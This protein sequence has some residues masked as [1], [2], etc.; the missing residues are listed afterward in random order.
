V[1]LLEVEGL[2][3]FGRGPR[4]G[5][6]QLA[7]VTLVYGENSSGKSTLVRALAMVAQLQRV[8]GSVDDRHVHWVD[9]GPWFS[10]GQPWDALGDGADWLQWRLTL[11]VNGSDW[12]RWR[13]RLRWEDRVDW[14]VRWRGR[15]EL[16]ATSS[17]CGW[18]G[19]SGRTAL[20]FEGAGPGDGPMVGQRLQTTSMFED[21]ERAELQELLALQEQEDDLMRLAGLGERE[22]SGPEAQPGAAR[23]ALKRLWSE[24]DRFCPQLIEDEA[25]SD[26]LDELARRLQPRLGQDR[27]QLLQRAAS[28]VALARATHEDTGGGLRW[29]DSEAVPW[30]A[31][32]AGVD[33][34][35]DPL[36]RTRVGSTRRR[37]G[38]TRRVVQ[39]RRERAS[40]ALAAR[41][42]RRAEALRGLRELLLSTDGLIGNFLSALEYVPAHRLTPARSYPALPE[43]G[44][45]AGAAVVRALFRDAALRERVSASADGLFGVQLT[46]T[47]LLSQ[48]GGETRPS[49]ML[50]L[51]VVEEDGASRSIAD[52]G[53][54]V[55]QVLPMLAAAS[56]PGCAVIEEP[57]SNLHPTA[58]AG[59]VRALTAAAGVA[60]DG[61]EHGHPRL[62]L[63]TH[64]EHILRQVLQLV[65]EGQ[66]RDDQVAINYVSRVGP[67]S[68]C[69]RVRTRRGQLLDPLLPHD[70]DSL[71]HNPTLSQI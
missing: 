59:L 4:R 62:V 11:S 18:T 68:S 10:L 41:E 3:G 7:P 31:G 65:E 29:P 33:F 15:D 22:L 70:R 69:R 49:G 38:S 43:S 35:W 55:A 6:L 36:S 54:G 67:A 27:E 24:D 2:R 56:Q 48:V 71:E 64:S 44:E 14:T 47:P 1:N 37:V 58:Q 32:S 42:W 66:L 60:P 61:P 20:E 63:E 25:D 45:P 50:E 12:G 57:E 28:A 26:A 19:A 16:T 17:E 13:R 34:L 51:R 23:Y 40:S 46:V 53:L 5:R 9:R 8:N 21:I 39:A 52:V 30:L